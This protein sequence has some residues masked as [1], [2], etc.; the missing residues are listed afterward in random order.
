MFGIIGRS[1][2]GKS[3]LV[4]T[5][6][7][8]N[9]PKAGKVIVGGRELSALPESRLRAARPEIGLIFQHFNLLSSRTVAGNVALPLELAGVPKPET[10][11]R[12]SE[13]LELVGLSAMRDRYRAQISGGQKQ[14]L[15]IAR[16]LANRP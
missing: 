3:S 4:R 10:D 9:R 15:G 16:A 8:L 2:A 12:V 13:L 1:G 7:L 5:I 11:R 6:N 14:R